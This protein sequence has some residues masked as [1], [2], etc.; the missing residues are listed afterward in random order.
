VSR[1]ASGN[2]G[3]S[4]DAVAVVR[5]GQDLKNGVLKK[6]EVG[7]QWQARNVEVFA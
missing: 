4:R 6:E 3:R 2:Q 1:P 7:V 5:Y